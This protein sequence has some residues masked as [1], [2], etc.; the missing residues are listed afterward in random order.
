M[1]VWHAG[2]W[3]NGVSRSDVVISDGDIDFPVANK[4]D[5]LLAMTQES[6]EKYIADV[7]EGGTVLVDGDLVDEVPHGR[8]RVFRAPIV[9]T[10]RDRVGRPIT[11]NLVAV[12]LIAGLTGVVTVPSLE[13]AVRA[14]V[15]RGTEEANLKALAAG[16]ELSQGLKG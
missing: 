11:A 6:V 7:K 2:P 3:A 15:P 5:F 13:S 4:L 16:L 10:A 1:Q 12:G 8:Y 9:V 14:R